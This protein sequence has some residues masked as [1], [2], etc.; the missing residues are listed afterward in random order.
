MVK[1]TTL[2]MGGVTHEIVDEA[3]RSEIGTLKDDVKSLQSKD[4]EILE[5]LD[6]ATNVGSA[7]TKTVSGEVV[8][9]EDVSPV[10]HEMSVK[11]NCP[12][13]VDPSTVTLSRCGKNFWQSK[14]MTYPRTVSGVT[15]DYDPNTQIY[16]FNG[17]STS[18]GD[19]YTMPNNTY[20]MRIN[21]GETWTL[22]VEVISGNVDGGTTSSGKISPLVNTSD[23]TNTIHANTE[24]LY[25]TKTYTESADITKMYFYVYSVGTV[26]NNFKIRV[27]FEQNNKPTEF[28]KHKDLSNYNPSSNGIVEGVTSL[29]PTMTL[30]TDTEDVT[31][32][33]K[34]N[35]DTKAYID[36]KFA[37]LQALI[38]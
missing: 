10:E 33:C 7:I 15:I 14:G 20:I 38:Q 3:A 17:T 27:Q 25:L 18:P 19:L 6:T 30:L 5:R 16:T 8:S 26:F 36:Q 11:V 37:E 21:K 29:S 1:M 22:K 28:E 23:Y 4:K 32:E 12:E 13:G 34:Y 31:V 2:T 35:V 9:V 24:S